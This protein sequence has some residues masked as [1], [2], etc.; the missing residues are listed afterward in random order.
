MTATNVAPVTPVATPVNTAPISPTTNVNQAQREANIASRQAT[1]VTPVTPVTPAP[2]ATPAPVESTITPTTPTTAQTPFQQAQAES[3]KIKA[4]NEAQMKLN[5]QQADLKAQERQQVAQETAKATTP[6]NQ[7]DVLNALV[8]GVSVA[9]QNTAA[10]RNAQMQ[11]KTY[12]KFA[13]MTPTQLVDNMKMGEIGTETA[14]LLASNPNYIKAKDDFD[15]FQ[16]NQ[17]INNMI[18]S[19]AEGATGKTTA[20]DHYQN[21]SDAI[22]KKLGITETNADA[23]A[24]IVS[25][26]PETLQLTKTVSNIAKQLNTLNTERNAVYEDLKKQYPDLSASAIMTLMA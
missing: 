8:S 17:S 16:K 11:Y 3:E 1:P 23:F 18:K 25:K 10:Y 2:V 12:Q 5:T 6:I 19:V 21:A 9:P 13:T 20:V 15:K 14:Q 22:A 4:Q 24:R 26:D 7:K